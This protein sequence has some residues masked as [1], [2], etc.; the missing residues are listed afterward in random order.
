MSRLRRVIH[1]LALAGT[2]RVSKIAAA[3]ITLII[4]GVPA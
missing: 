4:T 1:P 2:S 3:S